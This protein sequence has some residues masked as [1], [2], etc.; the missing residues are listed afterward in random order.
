MIFFS[1]DVEVAEVMVTGCSSKQCGIPYG[2]AVDVTAVIIDRA[3][4]KRKFKSSEASVKQYGM[5]WK[6]PV[7]LNYG[8]SHLDYSVILETGKTELLRRP[9][10][11]ILKSLNDD[12]SLCVEFDVHVT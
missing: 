2:Q 6:V 3:L 4:L 1:G 12:Y 9:G 10:V 5:T 11:F 7:S 8:V